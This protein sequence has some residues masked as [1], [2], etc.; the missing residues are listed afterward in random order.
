MYSV[1]PTRKEGMNTFGRN[2]YK[3]RKMAG[4]TQEELSQRLGYK[5]KASIGKIEN[6]N[7]EVPLS[8]AQRIADELKVDVMAL[9]HEERE[10]R[11][12]DEFVPY[13]EKAQEWQLESVR[14][15]LDMPLKKSSSSSS[16]VA[17]C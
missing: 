12:S 5:N 6:G 13:L 1:L 15:I 14:R 2:V 9:L 16:A 3:Y 11:I 7:N 4:M 17:N 8:M 10:T